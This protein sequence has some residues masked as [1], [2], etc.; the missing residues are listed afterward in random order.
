MDWPKCG[1]TVTAGDS[2]CGNCGVL[3][4]K[5]ADAVDLWIRVGKFGIAVAVFVAGYAKLKS[6]LSP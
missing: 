4:A 5:A 1:S 6:S 2:E 3:L